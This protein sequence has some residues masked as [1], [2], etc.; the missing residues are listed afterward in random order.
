MNIKI[1]LVATLICSVSTT[2]VAGEDLM[3]DIITTADQLYGQ[4]RFTEAR[5]AYQ[6][7]LQG[8][9]DDSQL[10]QKM[11]TLALWENNTDQATSYLQQA[12]Q[13]SGWWGRCWP[14][15]AQRAYRMG[16]V[17]ARKGDYPNAAL[18]YK[19]ATGLW[20]FGPL[21]QVKAMQQQMEAFGETLPYQ[22][23][24]PAE[25]R[26]SFIMLDPLPVVEI[27]IND[28]GPYR[29]FIDT[30]GA[31][32]ILTNRLARKL[33]VEGYGE[34]SG[35]FAGGKEGQVGLGKLD[36]VTLKEITV[37]NLPVHMME[38]EGID[39]IFNT[40]IDGAIGTSL[41]RHFYSTIHYANS[42]L[43]LRQITA[44]AR[45]EMDKLSATGISIPFWLVEQHMIM[46]RGQVNALPETLFFVDTGLADRGFLIPQTT[47]D[48]AG[49]SFDW[50]KASE[51]SGG[52]G[53]IKEL[54][55]E[56]D[57]VTLG[58]GDQQISK[59]QVKASKHQGELAIFTGALGFEV[60]GLIS[61]DFFRDTAL[62]LDVVDMRLILNPA[63]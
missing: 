41:L 42:E 30:G 14:M 49:L 48:A 54:H 33:G 62:T 27:H 35:S 55:F 53:K 13:H 20:A 1:V 63:L 57:K 43:I 11:G 56:L 17:Y 19:R 32:L 6:L 23:D 21:K 38:L 50:S 25:T 31:D 26:L 28:Q 22:I 34:L 29:F 8:H 10:L 47:A 2:S 5:A 24:G 4:G 36:S 44:Q 52:G 46:A 12:E 39:E 15:S 59:R 9:P 60:G 7:A 3:K 61:H 51:S 45:I 40:R 18:W 37:R 16:S 58:A